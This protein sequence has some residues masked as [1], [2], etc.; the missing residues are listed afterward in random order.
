ML[1]K[2][3]YG[4]LSADRAKAKSAAERLGMSKSG[5]RARRGSDSHPDEERET[6]K[7]A[8]GA[9]MPGTPLETRDLRLLERSRRSYFA[10][11]GA[12]SSFFVWG[13]GM[14]LW[15]CTFSR[16]ECAIFDGD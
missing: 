7:K 8:K 4:W 3:V 11:A 15:T 9:V 5:P 6:S 13:L 12:S 2:N 10:V 16:Q 14:S 1:R